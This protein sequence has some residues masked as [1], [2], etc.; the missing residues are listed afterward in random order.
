VGYLAIWG[1]KKEEALGRTLVI[2]GLCEIICF[3]GTLICSKTRVVIIIGRPKILTSAIYQIP[4]LFHAFS[5]LV[6]CVFPFLMPS[7]H[8]AYLCEN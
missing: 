7:K 6:G 4:G 8:L 5:H 2:M 3:T 1:L